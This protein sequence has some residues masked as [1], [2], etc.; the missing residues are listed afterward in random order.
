MRK[1]DKRPEPREWKKYRSTPGVRYQ[2]FPFLV[3]ALLEEQ[4]FIC[5]YCERRIPRQDVPCEENH[6]IDHL[7]PQ[8]KTREEGNDLDL[9]YTNMVICCP[10]NIAKNKDY[11]HCDK[12]KGSKLLTISP[13]RADMMSTIRFTPTGL[14]K[15]TDA[16]LDKELNEAGLNLN[17]PFLLQQRQEAWATVVEQLTK[18]GWTKRHVK[19]TL[20]I[21]ESRHTFIYHDKERRAFYPFCSM[22]CFML[23][24]KLAAGTL[25]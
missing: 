10:G 14:I 5:A 8:V 1:I 13:L 22:I 24:K 16:R 17:N 7:R 25:R 20:S 11:Y 12:A 2:S 3:D 21:W 15:S 6:R 9:V 4:G 19:N 23:R 18:M